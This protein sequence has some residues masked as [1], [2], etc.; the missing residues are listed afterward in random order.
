MTDLTPRDD[1][2]KKVSEILKRVDQLLK[3]SELDQAVQ[4][5][6][7]AKEVD[8]KNVYILAYEERMGAMLKEREESEIIESKRRAEEEAKKKEEE[9]KKKV[10][11]EKQRAQEEARRKAE[12]E[13]RKKEEE[14]RKAEEEERRKKE[15]E[16]RRKEEEEERKE[17]ERRKAEDLRRHQEEEREIVEEAR[18]KI[19]ARRKEWEKGESKQRKGQVRE[20]T[21][22]PRNRSIPDIS[23][24]VLEETKRKIL[25]DRKKKGAPDLSIDPAKTFH[26]A[27]DEGLDIY[28]R[29][30]VEAWAD[31]ATTPSEDEQLKSL[32]ASLMITDEDHANLERE[33]KIEAYS[34]AFRRAW[35]T[36]A[37]SPESASSLA[38]LR[39]KFKINI[40]EHEQIE[41]KLLWELRSSSQKAQILIIDDDEKL[42]KLVSDTLQD[43][44]YQ[45]VIF[46]TSD[47][48]FSFLQSH[49]PDMIVS[50]INLETSTMGGF[51]FY[52]KVR[53]IERLHEIP[54]IFLS[55][56]TDEVLVRTGKELG[57]DDYLTKPFS[58]ENLI[59]TIKGKLKRYRQLRKSRQ[60]K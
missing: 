51:T 48:A 42:L 21:P 24:N 38:E 59:A 18:R 49:T 13:R 37:I 52:E 11:E 47:E 57:V 25:E 34:N 32:R 60:K 33:A 1:V 6:A 30:M 17:Q 19:D 4:H 23:R 50:D 2:K 12:E 16:Q 44:G 56:L 53:E 46:T 29:V 3:A 43:V 41:T 10:E 28:T 31:G 7:R 58:E 5:L 36:G 15:A 35:S 40:E 22:E 39:K 9:A 14:H 55:G 26:H 20:E 27:Y 45:T 54:F 8:P